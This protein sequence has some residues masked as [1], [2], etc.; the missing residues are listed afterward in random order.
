MDSLIPLV[1]VAAAVVALLGGWMQILHKQRIDSFNEW[2]DSVMDRLTRTDEDIRQIQRQNQAMSTDLA[3]GYVQ[4]AEFLQA[5]ETIAGRIEVVV[6]NSNRR[7]DKL[8]EHLLT[9]A[10]TTGKDNDDP[11][12]RR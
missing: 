5:I 7:F 3:K 4:R 2:R 6:E 9:R 10:T 11:D 12:R 1:S 8:V